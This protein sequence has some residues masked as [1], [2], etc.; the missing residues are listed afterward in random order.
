MTLNPNRWRRRSTAQAWFG[1]CPHP[2]YGLLCVR[3]FLSCN[4]NLQM[5]GFKVNNVTVSDVQGDYA[6]DV[7]Y[8]PVC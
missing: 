5:L 8:V 6:A 1:K 3:E 2:I 4:N 7:G